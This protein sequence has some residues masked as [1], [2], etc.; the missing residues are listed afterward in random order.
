MHLLMVGAWP[1]LA[2]RLVGLPAR[3]SLLQPGPDGREADWVYRYVPVDYTDVAAAVEAATRI[4][5]ADPVDVVV[6]VRHYALPALAA[7][8]T[9]LGVRS[10]PGPV[11]SLDVDKAGV[12]ELLAAT[13][14]RPV[15]FRLCASESAVM[16]F[17]RELGFQA[18]VKPPIGVAKAGVHAIEGPEDVPGAWRHASA[19]ANGPV[20]V[21]ERL[22]GPEFSVEVRSVD[23][24]HEVL[25]VTEKECSGPPH[26]L[27]LG[28][29]VPARI[30]TS[31]LEIEAIRAVEALGH[32]TGPSHVEFVFTDDG[33]AVT[34]INR[35]MGGDRIFELLVLATGRDPMRETLLDALGEPHE[36]REI[37]RR[38]AAIRFLTAPFPGVAPELPSDLVLP[39]EIV[40]VHYAPGVEVAPP[41]TNG[42]RIGYVIAVAENAEKAAHAAEIARAELL[43]RLVKVADPPPCRSA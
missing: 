5:A 22:R 36:H 18:V 8:A 24:D 19:A 30:D 41:T 2:N 7:I 32:R 33:P 38:G 34:E 1:E 14:T 31:A 40:R 42:D 12:R 20:L 15:R 23:G 9:A 29:T 27:E 39:P 10:V 25:A 26:F 17:A 35:R 6:G 28:H 3:V 4:H 13:A 16:D 37:P 43:E 21:E 11:G